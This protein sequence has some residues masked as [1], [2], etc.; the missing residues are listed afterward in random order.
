MKGYCKCG[1][2]IDET[3]WTQFGM[4]YECWVKDRIT[5]A[6][7]RGYSDA[8]FDYNYEAD[9]DNDGDHEPYRMEDDYD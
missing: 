9:Y 8:L 3:G 7:N 4:C 6:Y 2:E 1:T 5:D